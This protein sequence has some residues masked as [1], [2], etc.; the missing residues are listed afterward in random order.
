MLLDDGAPY[1]DLAANAL[2]IIGYRLDHGF[3]AGAVMHR[4]QLLKP[5]CLFSTTALLGKIHA[6]LTQ[7]AL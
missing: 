7:P 3:L 5:C 6:G 4:L 1:G 2:D